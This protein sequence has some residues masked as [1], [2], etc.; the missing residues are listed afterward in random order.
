MKK[1]PSTEE[2]S[3]LKNKKQKDFCPCARWRV[4]DSRVKVFGSFFKKN[5]FLPAAR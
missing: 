5:R 3:F 2:S 1:K 4:R